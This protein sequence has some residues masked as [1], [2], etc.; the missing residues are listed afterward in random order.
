M[1]SKP[2]MATS[3]AN[4]PYRLPPKAKQEEIKSIFEAWHQA[5]PY[6]TTELH[7]KNP[8]QLLVAVVC[9][10]Q[11]T[12]K[13]VNK[14]FAEVFE[15]I[16]T[17]QD[18]LLW[19]EDALSQAIR[20][21][22]LFRSKAKN[23]IALSRIL[24]ENYHGEVPRESSQLESLPGVGRKTA[25]VV[26]NTLWGDTVIAVDTHVFRVARRLGFSRGQTP[27]AVETDLVHIIPKQYLKDAHHWLIL[28][29]RYICKAPKP[30]CHLCQISKWCHSSEKSC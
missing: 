18:M 1:R 2:I 19:G 13:A 26:R 30:A 24:I 28:H 16:K 7:Y 17:P 5:N 22:G 6:P 9:S 15:S 14:A 20:T 23:I 25:N 3:P 10:A 29:G 8:Y 12:D 4:K 21:I 11:T 27:A